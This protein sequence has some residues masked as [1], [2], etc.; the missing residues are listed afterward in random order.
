[1]RPALKKADGL[2]SQHENWGNGG[3]SFLDG[4]LTFSATTLVLRENGDD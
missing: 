1:M 4:R 2:L 3:K